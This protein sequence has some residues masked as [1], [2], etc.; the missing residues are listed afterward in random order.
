MKEKQIHDRGST[1]RESNR[2]EP[3]ECPRGQQLRECLRIRTR[4]TRPEPQQ[5]TEQIQWSSP[6]HIRQRNEQER[7]ETVDSDDDSGL[8]RGVDNGDVEV[9]GHGRVGRVDDCRVHAAEAGEQTDLEEAGD[10]EV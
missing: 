2:H 7:C 6:I 5:S 8:V 3:I 10:F 1:K 4:K 9:L